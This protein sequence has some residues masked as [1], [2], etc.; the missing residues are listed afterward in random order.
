MRLISLFVNIY[1]EHTHLD[2]P[3]GNDLPID[4]GFPLITATSPRFGESPMRT[5]SSTNCRALFSLNSKTQCVQHLIIYTFQH[6]AF[7]I[8]NCRIRDRV[9][10]RCISTNTISTCLLWFWFLSV[11]CEIHTT[12]YGT[13]V[14]SVFW[15]GPCGSFQFSVLC[16]CFV[17]LR[18][19]LCVRWVLHVSQDCPFLIDSSV[20]C[21]A[22]LSVT[23]TFRKAVV[24][25]AYPCYK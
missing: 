3:R 19:V 23:F 17:Y 2:I 9:G 11:T 20:F 7:V 5:L 13:W 14:T 22:Y 4:T 6:D 1:L 18:S 10:G 16:F 25:S 24:F 21:N 8:L 15:W 12:L